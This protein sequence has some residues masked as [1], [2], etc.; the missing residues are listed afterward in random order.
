M[1]D[2]SYGGF[3]SPPG[4][5]TLSQRTPRNPSVVAGTTAI[6]PSVEITV[7]SPSIINDLEP[8]PTTPTPA[9]T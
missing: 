5:A 2:N 3:L 4:A 1:A 7:R 9:S 8:P 6:S